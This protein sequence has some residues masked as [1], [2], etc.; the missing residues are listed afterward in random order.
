MT[1]RP[2]AGG[3]RP[4]PAPPPATGQPAH[5]LREPGGTVPAWRTPRLAC[6]PGSA[7]RCDRPI[8]GP[9]RA[10]RLDHRAWRRR[11]ARA[12]GPAA[13]A[14]SA[15]ASGCPSRRHQPSVPLRQ[16]AATGAVPRRRRRPP[17][18]HASARSHRGRHP[19]GRSSPQRHSGSVGRSHRLR[20]LGRGPV[21]AIWDGPL[22]LVAG[23]VDDD[24]VRAGCRRLSSS[25]SPAPPIALP[26]VQR[27]HG[28][29]RAPSGSAR[30]QSVAGRGPTAAAESSR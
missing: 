23:T 25:R 14:G 28:R 16:G 7:H 12:H 27:R 20:S 11:R 9:A 17:H 6:R 1:T 24:G 19:S 13:P 22:P 30:R 4:R 10:G 29:G 26:M 3:S 8:R 21:G 18:S 15:G 5:D 2:M